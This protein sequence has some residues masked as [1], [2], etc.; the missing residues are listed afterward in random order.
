M[1]PSRRQRLVI[2]GR[3]GGVTTP[4]DQG[5]HRRVDRQVGALSRFLHR[6]D[7]DRAERRDFRDRRPRRRHPKALTPQLRTPCAGR[8]PS[9]AE[10]SDID[11]GG[12]PPAAARVRTPSGRLRIGTIMS[13]P[14][15]T[16]SPD[17]GRRA[18]RP[19]PVCVTL[20]AQSAEYRD[21]RAARQR[22]ACLR[23][24]REGPKGRG[25]APSDAGPPVRRRGSVGVADQ[26]GQTGQ[27]GRLGS[28]LC[29]SLAWSPP[30]TRPWRR[31]GSRRRGPWP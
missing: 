4:D 8:L 10:Q 5:R 3:S 18:S 7:R 27:V 14:N 31:S 24:A 9:R 23:Q 21:Q 6:R 30:R 26:V 11:G 29:H 15:A 20:G 1:P 16:G 19:T 17:A 22:D 25:P 2:K 13:Q 12:F 28:A